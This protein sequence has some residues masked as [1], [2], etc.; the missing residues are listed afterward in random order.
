MTTLKLGTYMR[1]IARSRKKFTPLL[2]IGGNTFYSVQ[3]MHENSVQF[4]GRRAI[5]R[6]SQLYYR[7]NATGNIS[8]LRIFFEGI[9]DIPIL[10]AG[11]YGAPVIN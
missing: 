4:L 1:Y 6:S 3:N 7:A 2:R 8:R 11:L 10:N 9:S 5:A